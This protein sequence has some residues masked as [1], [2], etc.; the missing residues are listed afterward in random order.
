VC[1][2]YS[3]RSDAD[4]RGKNLISLIWW[5]LK[6]EPIHR[7]PSADQLECGIGPQ[8]I[9]IVGVLVAAADREYASAE[10]IDKPVHHPRRVAP[11]R[12]YPS[13]LLSRA[14]PRRRTAIAR[15]ITPPSTSDNRS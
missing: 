7:P 13:E 6:I 8:M 2:C 14:K 4:R 3:A 5:G 15:S 12:E 10:H 9:E 1:R 11:I